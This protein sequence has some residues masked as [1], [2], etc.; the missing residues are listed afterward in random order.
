[1]IKKF[2][3]SLLHLKLSFLGDRVFLERGR[4]EIPCM[5]CGNKFVS[6][7]HYGGIGYTYDKYCERCMS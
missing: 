5:N 4:K 2:R 6:Y 1:M 7:L 3:V